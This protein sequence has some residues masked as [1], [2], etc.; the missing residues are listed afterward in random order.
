MSDKIIV[1]N[2]FTVPLIKEEYTP[3]NVRVSN[4]RVVHRLWYVYTSLCIRLNARWTHHTS[5]HL[6]ARWTHN[7]S[8]RLN[9]W[10]ECSFKCTIGSFIYFCTLIIFLIQLLF[11]YYLQLLIYIFSLIQ[12]SMFFFNI[13]CENLSCV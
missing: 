6:N 4:F 7:T 9:A 8:V 5:V 3:W 12:F 1:C 2:N 10:W 13:I 11:L